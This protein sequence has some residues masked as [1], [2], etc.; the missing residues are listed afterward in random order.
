MRYYVQLFNS[1]MVAATCNLMI[2]NGKNTEI[3]YLRCNYDTFIFEEYAVYF[4]MSL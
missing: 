2:L 4:S 3:P 1:L